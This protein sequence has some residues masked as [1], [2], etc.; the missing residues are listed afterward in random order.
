MCVEKCI[1]YSG[2]QQC[3][4]NKAFSLRVKLADKDL[5]L[6]CEIFPNKQWFQYYNSPGA[7]AIIKLTTKFACLSYCALSFYRVMAQRLNVPHISVF[8]KKM[9]IPK[10][11][12]VKS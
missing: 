1:S 10:A 3:V 4:I 12:A 2:S 9:L 7:L 11:S 5:N 6:F 8:N